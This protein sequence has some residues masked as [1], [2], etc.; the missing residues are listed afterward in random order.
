M[1]EMSFTF[2]DI[3]PI[4]TMIAQVGD[5]LEDAENHHGTNPR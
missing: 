1:I 3:D 5:R 4:P 2:L